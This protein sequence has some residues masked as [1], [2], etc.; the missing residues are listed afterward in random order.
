MNAIRTMRYHVR[1]LT[2][3]LLLPPI[4]L[5]I[6]YA[7]VARAEVGKRGG[8]ERAVSCAMK[9]LRAFLPTTAGLAVN[10]EATNDSLP[11]G[12]PRRIWILDVAYATGSPAAA[13]VLDDATGDV[14]IMSLALPQGYLGR[15]A[16][17]D[18]A[19]AVAN[20][21]HWMEKVVPGT[22]V[23][24]WRRDGAPSRREGIWRVMLSSGLRHARVD[25][26]AHTGDLLSVW[27]TPYEPKTLRLV[28]R[29][30]LTQTR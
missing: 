21:R 3:V 25:V 30:R 2:V 11:G 5:A 8:K 14:V 17:L 19:E 18:S 16:A 10:A 12:L 1:M 24:A 6:T 22:T 29:A 27:I 28:A 23:S 9:H 15:G 4:A 20:A 7:A 26:S 13:I